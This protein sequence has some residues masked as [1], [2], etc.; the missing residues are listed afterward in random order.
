[1]YD[2]YLYGQDSTPGI[3]AVEPV[4]HRSLCEVFIRNAQGLSSHY[5]PYKHFMYMNSANP[6]AWHNSLEKISLGGGQYYDLLL[7]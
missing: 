2:P 5:V 7:E 6:M 1:M 3:V 4:K